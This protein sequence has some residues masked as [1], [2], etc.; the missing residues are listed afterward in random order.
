[1]NGGVQR[2]SAGEPKRQSERE[3]GIAGGVHEEGA[4]GGGGRREERAPGKRGSVA[5]VAATCKAC[6]KA[7][8]ALFSLFVTREDEKSTVDT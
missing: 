2:K 5:A 3:V 6:R 1:M 7:H 8:R 4:G